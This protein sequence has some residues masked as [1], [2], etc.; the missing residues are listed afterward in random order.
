MWI[1]EKISAN[2]NCLVCDTPMDE[3]CE[4]MDEGN[5]ITCP[6]CDC[7][8]EFYKQFEYEESN[9]YC[10]YPWTKTYFV[11]TNNRE[12]DKEE[13]ELLYE[14]GYSPKV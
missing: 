9:P 13:E 10:D 1:I 3:Y 4:K 12:F 6:H 5:K 7:E 8:F 11:F 2:T 14:D